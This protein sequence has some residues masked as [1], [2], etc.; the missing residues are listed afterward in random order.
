MKKIV[1]LLFFSIATVAMAQTHR[2]AFTLEIAA[3]ATHQY[4]ANIPESPY[5]VKEKI[6]QLYCGEKLFVE[7]ETNGDT[8]TAMQVVPENKHP[9]KTIEIDFTQNA[10]DRTSIGTTL[11][12]KNP[13]QKR[14]KYSAVMF[15]PIEQ[16]WTSTSIIPVYPGLMGLEMWPHAIVTMVLEN[17]ELVK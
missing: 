12:V 4:G 9:E 7:C 16:T 15:T 17:W 5:F 3:D 2:K 6:L 14:L 13:F 10:E 8:I 1:A 11:S